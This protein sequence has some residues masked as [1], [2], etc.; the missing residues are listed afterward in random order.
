MSLAPQGCSGAWGAEQSKLGRRKRLQDRPPGEGRGHPPAASR[1]H[2][3]LR[4][5]SRPAGSVSLL[6]QCRD[7]LASGATGP[8]SGGLVSTVYLSPKVW[9]HLSPE[10]THP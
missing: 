4:V 10:A 5:A 6:T 9:A 7:Q 1:D 8:H 3:A 2:T